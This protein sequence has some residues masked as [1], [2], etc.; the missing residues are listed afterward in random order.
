MKFCPECGTKL[1]GMPKFCP[2]CG[3]KFGEN[4]K[5]EIQSANV[6]SESSPIDVLPQPKPADSAYDLGVRLEEIVEHIF[7]ADGYTTQRRQ[8][9]PGV[10]GYHNE[11]DIVAIRGKDQVAIECKNF[12]QPVGISQ[13]RDFAEKI[14]DL[15]P[16]WRGIFIGYNDF[17]EDATQFAES[18]NIE[19]IGHDEVMEKWFALSVGRWGKQG[20]KL[21]I[22]QALPVNIDYIAATSLD[23]ANKEKVAI[24]DVRLV[25]HPYVRYNYHFKRVFTD[26]SKERHKFDD[27]GTVVI[28]L[29][30]NSILNKPTVKNVEGLA[31]R[32][33]QTLSSKG[34]LENA[35][36]SAIFDEV[37]KNIPKN[38]IP[39]SISEDYRVSKL[40][41]DYSKR[42]V[43][44]IALDYII[45]KNSER[46]S[47]VVGSR[48]AF[49][50]WR[51]IDFVPDRKDIS[52]DNGEVV[53]VPKWEI[54]FNAMGTIY[55]REILAC[56]GKR[57]EDTIAY[58]PHHFKL[59]LFE[60]RQ[61]NFAVCEKC[62]TAFCKEHGRVCEV[63]KMHLCENHAIICTSCKMAFCED[64][65]SKKCEICG[66]FVCDECIRTCPVCGKK[67]GKDHL[68]KCDVCGKEVCSSCISV[69][70]LIKKKRTCTKCQ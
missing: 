45:N 4:A 19:Q 43:N 61:K 3:T 21:V 2:E 29:L 64:H 38:E 10:K 18:R 35:R 37:I 63:C 47:Y 16:G 42:D 30:D 1:E 69:T 22:E 31:Q 23:L 56:S 41:V 25:Y 67:V 9:L 33:T 8:R 54:H 5:E 55:S 65:I 60:V 17:T 27:R 70:G 58:C 15:G 20:E 12:S 46:I 51:N 39:L 52:I 48:S 68:V 57:L 66:G 49:P 7:K 26:P 44:R 24:N 13:V 36:R 59:G 34:R 6:V 11:I 50:D 62:G 32:V 28:D 14:L 53:S 40:A